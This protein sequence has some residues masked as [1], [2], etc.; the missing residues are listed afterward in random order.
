MTSGGLGRGLAPSPPCGRCTL[1][2][3]H[4]GPAAKL[5]SMRDRSRGARMMRNYAVIPSHA[6]DARRDGNGSV[7]AE[8][9]L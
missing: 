3:S 9:A 6:A 1:K 5:K 2:H 7:R 8:N 4:L